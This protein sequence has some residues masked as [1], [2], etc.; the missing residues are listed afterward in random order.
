MP[1]PVTLCPSPEFE[2]EPLN[3]RVAFA[4]PEAC[5]LNTTA[6]ETLAPA[7][8]VTGSERPLSENSELLMPAADTVIGPLFADRA[9]VLVWLDPTTTLPKFRVAGV[10]S[11]CPGLALAPDSA[12]ESVG[13]EA[14][15]MITRLPILVPAAWGEK[16]TLNVAA[17]PGLKVT[18]GLMPL[19]LNP[20][21]VAV[22][23]ETVS[24]E[25]PLFVM[26]SES[27]LLLARG[28]VP[29]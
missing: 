11:I 25:S 27:S 21:P 17:C 15:D 29:N 7:A 16:A 1:V 22:M 13:F 10:T 20:D 26:V 6:N 8:K 23:A 28:I 12:T 9:A 5:G 2:A 18:G 19:K 14:L 3:D 24:A 4:D